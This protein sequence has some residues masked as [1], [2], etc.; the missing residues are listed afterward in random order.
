MDFP[1]FLE[2]LSLR[3]FKLGSGALVAANFPSFLEGLSLRLA[4]AGDTWSPKCAFPF[5]F[6]RAFI[7]A[8]T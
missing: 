4:T 8:Q 2:G 3:P 6:G 5:L 7:E 1:S